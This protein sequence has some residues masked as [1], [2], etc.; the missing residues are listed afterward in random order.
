[1]SV[2]KQLTSSSSKFIVY[3]IT[4][5]MFHQSNQIN[6]CF[7][8][9]DC[10][11]VLQTVLLVG[12]INRRDILY[13][14]VFVLMISYNIEKIINKSW[15]IMEYQRNSSIAQP[16]NARREK[17]QGKRVKLLSRWWNV[18]KI[19]VK[20]IIVLIWVKLKRDHRREKCLEC[21]RFHDHFIIELCNYACILLSL[22]FILQLIY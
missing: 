6:I 7:V 9:L 5:P 21:S 14:S 8:Y 15:K 18:S 16:N 4:F 1:M 2:L 22:L 11:F 3:L 17:T 20:I 12:L 19:K 10:Y 13:K